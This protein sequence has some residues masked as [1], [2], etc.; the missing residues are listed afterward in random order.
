[1][2]IGDN[3]FRK[4]LLLVFIVLSTGCDN[5]PPSDL[6]VGVD[7]SDADMNDAMQHAVDTFPLFEANWKSIPNDGV[8]VKFAIPT[9]DGRFEFVWFEPLVIANN[10]IECICANDTI[11]TPGLKL[12]DRR[13]F[14]TQDVKDWV[15]FDGNKCF[16]GYTMRVMAKIDPEFV[17]AFEFLDF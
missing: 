6:V 12:G 14:S 9:S 15:I 8:G 11:D 7:P 17:P 16:G 13:V 4:C 2:T 3:M 10:E 5:N 1:M